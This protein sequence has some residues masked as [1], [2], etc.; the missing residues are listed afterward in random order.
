MLFKKVKRSKGNHEHKIAATLAIKS[1]L[2][3]LCQR[4]EFCPSLVKR[5]KGRFSN[6]YQIDRFF[7]LFY[8]LLFS[9]LLLFAPCPLLHAGIQDRVV[10]FVD[11]TAI[12]LSDLEVK[13]AETLKVTPNITTME[14]L[15]TMVNRTLL[16]REAKRFRLEAPSEEELLKEYIDLKLRAFIRIRDREIADF[17][18]QHL[19]DFQGKELDEVRDQIETYLIEN[20]L[21]QRLK[22]HIDELRG[23]SCVKVQFHQ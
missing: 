12:T 5:G 1:L 7:F 15:N 13:Y 19:V 21:N 8:L 2:T 23:K 17:Y 22:S 18:Q 6:Q 10:A 14:V 4:E 11:N 16:L 20:E 9:F 3:S